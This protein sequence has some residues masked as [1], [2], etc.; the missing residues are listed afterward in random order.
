[1]FHLNLSLDYDPE[2]W[3]EIPF[4]EFGELNTI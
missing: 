4:P 2:S 1:M 3:I